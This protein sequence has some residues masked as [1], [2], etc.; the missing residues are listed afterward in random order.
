MEVSGGFV[1]FLLLSRCWRWSWRVWR[2]VLTCDTV[3]GGDA[4]TVNL[5]S[6]PTGVGAEFISTLWI[7]GLDCVVVLFE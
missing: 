7:G 5:Q 1:Y 4:V 6:S 2:T 3:E